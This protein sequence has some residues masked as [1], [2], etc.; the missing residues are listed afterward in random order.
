MKTS[1]AWLWNRAPPLLVMAAVLWAGNAVASRMAV[2]NVSPMT[3]VGVR[4]LLISVIMALAAPAAIRASAPLLWRNKGLIAV[5]AVV[6]LAGFNALL[7][8][9]AHYT[10]AVNIVLLQCLMPGLV[11]IG[12]GLLGARAAATQY[13]GVAITCLGVA[14]VATH[15]HPLDILSLQL[16]FGDVLVLVTCVMGAIYNLL[17]PRRP[18]TT[19]PVY[20]A[21]LAMASVVI[22]APMMAAEAGIGALQWPN[23]VGW[24]VILFTALGPGIGAQVLFL[25]GVDLIGPARAG[26]YNNLTPVFGAVLGVFV[27]GETFAGYHAVGLALVLAGIWLGERGKRLK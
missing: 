8:I 9:S 11:L 23:A 25:R 3:L 26:I 15:G 10:T 27:L 22:S 12:G 5:M 18:M 1:S 24:G 13:A 6:G 19:A 14:I 16:N 2:G 21:A 4:W 20:F 17:L 7:Y